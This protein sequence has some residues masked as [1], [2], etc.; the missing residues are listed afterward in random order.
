MV[1]SSNKLASRASDVTRRRGKVQ[2]IV[3]RIVEKN[4]RSHG[5]PAGLLDV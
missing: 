3:E 2:E 4:V 1:G 5:V